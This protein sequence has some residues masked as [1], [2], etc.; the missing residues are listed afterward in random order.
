MTTLFTGPL[1]VINVGLPTFAEPIAATGG[2]AIHLN[3]QPPANGRLETGHTLTRLMFDPRIDDANN[4]A[5]KA[6]LAANPVL[7]DILPAWVLV[8]ELS[9]HRMLLHAGPPVAWEAM[10]GPMRGAIIGAAL[11]EQWADTAEEAEHLAGSGGIEF[12]PCHHFG[13]VGPMAG[14]ISPSMPLWL[15]TDASGKRRAYASL[16]EGLGKVLR[17]GAHHPAVIDRLRWMKSTLAPVL[18]EALRASGGIAIKPLMAQ[19]LHMGDELHNRNTAA[20]SL[21]L[22]KIAPKLIQSPYPSADAAESAKFMAANDHFF[23]N[24]SMA[25]CKMTMDAAHGIPH[26]SLITAMARNGVEFGIRTSGTG[27]TWFTA[28]APAVQGLFFPGYGAQDAAPD[29]GDSAIME[30]AGLGGFA[31]AAAPAITRF[32]GGTAE[33]ALAITARMRRIAPG[34][35]PAFTIPALGFSGVP[36]GIDARRVVDRSIVP[37]MNTGIAHRDAGVGQIGAGLSTAPIEC[38]IAAIDELGRRLGDDV[39]LADGQP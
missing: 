8:P 17:F 11:F 5:L 35:N 7:Q 16:N 4:T 13:A 28:P 31:M 12:A 21:F 38:F 18:A 9:R 23:L 2:A 19:S 20:T 22:K 24:V 14:V 3:W 15:V 6:I 34:V 29:L 30:T 36:T 27:D 32:V 26:C 33:D 37:V 10:C 39:V 25:A 1:K